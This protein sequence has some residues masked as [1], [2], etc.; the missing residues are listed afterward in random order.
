MAITGGTY[1]PIFPKVGFKVKQIPT[2]YKK[3]QYNSYNY[4][5]GQG[6]FYLHTNNEYEVVV[7]QVGTI[8]YE[9]PSD[10]EKVTIDGNTYYEY[11]NIVYEKIQ[12]NGTRAYQVVGIIDID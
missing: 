3:V 9:L 11:G 4:Y 2:N 1:V 6:V 5:N 12:I 7:P 10:Y 8:V